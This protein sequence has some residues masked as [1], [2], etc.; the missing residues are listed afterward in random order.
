VSG[1]G[2]DANPCS[3]TAPCKT[4]AGAISKTAANGIINCLDPAGY[5]AVTITKA[6]T[7]RCT[8]TNGA[9]LSSG[10][11]AVIVNVTTVGAVVVLEDLAIEGSGGASGNT[12]L[13]GVRVLGNAPIL[14]V[15]N[16]T[17]Q[18]FQ[19]APT[20]GANGNGIIWNANSGAGE[21]YIESSFISDNGDATAGGGILIAP[22]AA[23][24]VI[25]DISNTELSNNRF[26]LRVDTNATTGSANIAVRSSVISGGLAGGVVATNGGAPDGAANVMVADSVIASNQQGVIASGSGTATVRV[27]NSTFTNNGVAFQ[28]S[29][30]GITQ[31]FQNNAIDGAVGT[32]A[33]SVPQQ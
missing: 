20:P 17:I 31:S 2:D 16:V 30:G 9:I 10:T 11:N 25:G 8:G 7:I 3:R 24:S 1:V 32:I 28:A 21:L 27:R 5:G 12:G 14:H 18:Q 6:I 4:F 23:S 29:S 26:G 15:R 33:S 13:N 22:G 19:A